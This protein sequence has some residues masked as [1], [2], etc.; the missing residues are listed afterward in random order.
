N[1][2]ESQ[3]KLG[4]FALQGIGQN[5]DITQAIYWYKKAIE[6]FNSIHHY[7]Y[8]SRANER[9]IDLYEKGYKDLISENEYIEYL[10][11]PVYSSNDSARITLREYYKKGYDVG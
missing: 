2:F 10:K 3:L 4:D 9:L 5:E 1:C 11:V 7:S 8:Y 6:T